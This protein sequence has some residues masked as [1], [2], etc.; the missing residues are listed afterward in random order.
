MKNHRLHFLV[1]VLAVAASSAPVAA[2]DTAEVSTPV[3]ET[4]PPAAETAGERFEGYLWMDA[5]GHPLPFQSDQEIEEFLETSTVVTMKKIPVGVTSPR[6][7]LL[8]G[9]GVRVNA[10]FKIVDEKKKDVVERTAGQR[11]SYREWRDWHLYDAAAYH[12]DRLLDLDRVPPAIPRRIKRSEGTLKIWLEDTITDTARR[13][14]E[15]KPPDI[16]RWNQQR[17]IMHIFDNLVANRDSNLGNTLIDRNWRLWFI[18]CGRCFGT[19]KELLYPDAITHCE[20][21]LWRA[22]NALDEEQLNA[23]LGSFLTKFEIDAMLAR[24]DKLVEHIQGLIEEW[25]EVHV[26]FDLPPPGERASWGED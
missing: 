19:S 22:L 26:F 12:V 7:V 3:Q 9:E 25:G 20:R 17:Q 24:R 21:D 8:A 1:A 10:A 4:A 6:K 2:D 23:R 18:D 5:D 11:H 14:R 16:V 13:D 15:I